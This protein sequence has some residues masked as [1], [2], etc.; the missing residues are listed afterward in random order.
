MIVVI[1]VVL[2]VTE[3]REEQLW[4]ADEPIDVTIDGIVIEVNPLFWN[5]DAL[6]DVTL[7]GIVIEY[8]LLHVLKIFSFK[9]LIFVVL[10]ITEVREEQL[11]NADEPIDVTIDGIVIEVNP[12]FWKTDVSIVVIFDDDK[13]IEVSDVQFENAFWA[14]IFTGYKIPK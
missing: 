13:L 6:I 10:K 1:F 7:V 2:K 14:I 12:L 8:S 4:N 9:I 3:V 11:W 5:A